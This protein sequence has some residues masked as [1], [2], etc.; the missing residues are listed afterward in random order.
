[1]DRNELRI[2]RVSDSRLGTK[3]AR[4][5]RKKTPKTRPQGR[6]LRKLSATL[7][8]P[9]T[10]VS[11]AIKAVCSQ[12]EGSEVLAARADGAQKMPV[13]DVLVRYFF[14]NIIRFYTHSRF[15][16]FLRCY[17]WSILIEIRTR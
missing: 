10:T 16:V 4:P 6:G 8:L 17:C 13:F 14:W 3:S 1:M 15:S 11:F 5:R 9:G 12:E 2:Q 7:G